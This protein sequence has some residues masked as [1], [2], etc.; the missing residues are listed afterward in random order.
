MKD[1][2]KQSVK[3]AMKKAGFYKKLPKANN[4]ITKKITYYSDKS[5]KK[6]KIKTDNIQMIIKDE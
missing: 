6:G 1:L 3:K 4:V 2:I 5:M